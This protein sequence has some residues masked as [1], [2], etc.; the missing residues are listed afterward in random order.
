MN[1][2]SDIPLI[3]VLKND[4]SVKFLKQNNNELSLSQAFACGSVLP[5]SIVDLLMSA[6]Y[7][8]PNSMT[9]IKSLLNGETKV[10]QITLSDPRFSKYGNYEELFLALLLDYRMLCL[11]I[12]RLSDQNNNETNNTIRYVITAPSNDF[13]LTSSDKVT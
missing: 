10:E 2:E 13:P 6:S 11:G 3:S 12:Y 9:L 7:F 4:S 1:F 5:V 8:K